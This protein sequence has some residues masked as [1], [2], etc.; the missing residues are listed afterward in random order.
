LLSPLGHAPGKPVGRFSAVGWNFIFLDQLK[1]AKEA[2]LSLVHIWINRDINK[3][4]PEGTENTMLGR[5]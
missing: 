1:E 5:V 2:K 4:S 3:R